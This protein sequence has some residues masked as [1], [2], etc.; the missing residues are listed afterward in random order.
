MKKFF[1]VLLLSSAFAISQDFKKVG[2]TGYVFLEI[3]VSAKASGIGD[4]GVALFYT[5]ADAIFIN[6]ALT[7]FMSKRNSVN[8]TFANWLSS[9]YFI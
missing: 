9:I 7:G 6:P 5:G 3:P 1:L 2:T 4:A 8:F